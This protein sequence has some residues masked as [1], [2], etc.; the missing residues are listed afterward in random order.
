MRRILPEACP[1]RYEILRPAQ[2]GVERKAQNDKSM[3]LNN[4]L[5]ASAGEG[6]RSSR[7]TANK[8][9]YLILVV[10]E[11]YQAFTADDSLKV[12]AN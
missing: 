7:H 11:A 8:L 5:L 3:L 4:H 6:L 9:L 1:E 10:A 2:D 12:K